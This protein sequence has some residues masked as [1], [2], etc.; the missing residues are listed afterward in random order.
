MDSRSGRGTSHERSEEGE[1]YDQ[2]TETISQAEACAVI[3]EDEVE[4]H[5]PPARFLTLRYPDR[6]CFFVER[7]DVSARAWNMSLVASVLYGGHIFYVPPRP[8]FRH[9]EDPSPQIC[10]S[11]S[12]FVCQKCDSLVPTENKLASS[13][14]KMPCVWLKKRTSI[15]SRLLRPPDR[16]CA[17]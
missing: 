1:R 13:V 10:A 4:V 17:D 7:V 3:V 14:L 2:L 9:Q 8:Y 6:Q 12:G 16:L 11:T 5:L 15:L